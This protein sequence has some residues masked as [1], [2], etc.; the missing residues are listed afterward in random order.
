[1][2]ANWLS[3]S[4]DVTQ[5]LSGVLED[6]LQTVSQPAN[7]RRLRQGLLALFVLWGVLA[8]TQLIWGFLPSRDM[9]LPETAVVINPVTLAAP[10]DTAQAVNIEQVQG[11]HLFGEAGAAADAGAIE[12]EPETAA[13]PLEGIEKDARK[14]RLD[15]KLRG[16][17]AS[18]DDGL[19]YAIIEHKSRQ[20][21][22]AVED[23]LPVSGQVLLAKVMPGQVVLDNGGTY[24][25][26]QLFG[27][28]P[29]DNQLPSERSVPEAPKRA[30]AV[31]P[32]VG[33][34]SS[35]ADLARSYRQR[36]Y[37]NPQTLAEVV[38]ISAVREDGQLLG[39][40][41]APGKDKQQF[42]QLGFKPGDLV[43]SV[44]GIEL[45]DPANTLRLYQAMRSASEAVFDLQ[46]ND[47]PVTISVSL[48]GE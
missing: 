28:S 9:A 21:I 4:S 40:R 29:L 6:A 2:P 35:A 32:Q 48:A 33:A 31:A 14:T 37:E 7:A 24:E 41:V 15:L 30:A 18:T 47:Q 13:A 23:K 1:M 34:D 45:N 19:G 26:L 12:L 38:T 17:V 39:Y 46:R 5:R 16:I 11:W 27:E 10:S 8:M 36:L 44:N 43:T 20:D 3:N 22:Y 42:E 25:L